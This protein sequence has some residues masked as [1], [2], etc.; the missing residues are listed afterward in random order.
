MK[1]RLLKDFLH[2][3]TGHVFE[4]DELHEVNYKASDRIHV[5]YA[6]QP[7]DLVTWLELKIIEEVKEET[8][9][10]AVGTDALA[11]PLNPT[12]A[13]VIYHAVWKGSDVKD[14]DIFDEALAK[15]I[16]EVP[17]VSGM[18]DHEAAHCNADALLVNELQRLGY[19]KTCQAFDD[20]IKWYA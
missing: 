4:T 8:P 14:V 2:Y 15:K 10:Y 13:R 1:Y 11:E 12:D 17:L 20:L 16:A 6:L 18:P 7:H 19:H 5:Q 3:K 9:T